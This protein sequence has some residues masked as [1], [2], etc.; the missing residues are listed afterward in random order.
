MFLQSLESLAEDRQDFYGLESEDRRINLGFDGELLRKSKYLT[1]L[2]RVVEEMEKV[3]GQH[4]SLLEPV[5]NHRNSVLTNVDST[6]DLPSH[7][8]INLPPRNKFRFPKLH[9]DERLD[10]V[11]KFIIMRV[12]STPET[13]D[14][15]S[16]CSPGM[17]H[18]MPKPYFRTLSKLGNCDSNFY[19]CRGVEALI[20]DT[21]CRKDFILSVINIYLIIYFT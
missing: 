16:I 13:E 1:F 11:R 20:D 2:T 4:K 18:R 7:R 19:E 5:A 10:K 6:D 8:T 15:L 21:N 17:T 3:I 9:I 12:S 14:W